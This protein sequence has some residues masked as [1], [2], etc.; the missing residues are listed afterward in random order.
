MT[1]PVRVLLFAHLSRQVPEPEF[2]AEVPQGATVR[3]LARQLQQQQG[4]DLSG[5]MAAVN[6]NYA[7]PDTAL[8]AGDEVAFL[9]PVAGGSDIENEQEPGLTAVQVTAEPLS[10]AQ[11]E[12]FLVRPRYGA[13]SYFVGTVR[14]PN[15]G[16]AVT[17]IQYEAY[18]S[19]AEKVLREAADQARERFGGEDGDLAVYLAHR[20]GRLQP[21][22][23]SIV[24]GVGSPHRRA[25][26][27]AADWLIE[28]VK[29]V[30]PVWK[31]E[32]LE[33]GQRWVEGVSPAET[34]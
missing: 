7:A 22:E 1:F 5:C 11:A 25:A 14:S 29:A 21:A 4:L 3:D 9:P 17:L 18:A 24:I 19:M 23:A 32:E 6:E 34:L 15:K 26:L 20:T 33:D 16:Q 13:Q 12:A 8:H 10:L 30:I 2:A 27:D 31:L 28:H